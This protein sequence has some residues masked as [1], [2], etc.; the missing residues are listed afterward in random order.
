ME[1]ILII[2]DSEDILR[3]IKTYLNESYEILTAKFGEKG[4]EIFKKERPTVVISD[5]KMPGMDGVD[6]LREIKSIDENVDVILMTGNGDMDDVIKSLRF[7]A[8]DFILKPMDVGLLEISIEKALG[9]HRAVDEINR[10]LNEIR[11][12]ITNLGIKL[13]ITSMIQCINENVELNPEIL[14]EELE[15]IN[16]I[17]EKWEGYPQSV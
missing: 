9:K 16:A 2:D 15:K 11:T 12:S 7:G 5:I 10:I 8:T 17:C 1:K 6:V 3:T 4:I 13:S 14:K